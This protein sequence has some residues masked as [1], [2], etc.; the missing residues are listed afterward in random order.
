M[1]YIHVASA[2]ADR[3]VRVDLATLVGFGL[4]GLAVY[5]GVRDLSLVRRLFGMPYVR[6]IDVLFVAPEVLTGLLVPA[7]GLVVLGIALGYATLFDRRSRSVAFVVVLTVV[8]L[9]WS[10]GVTF[11]TTA[12]ALAGAF[13]V[14]EL[15][16]IRVRASGS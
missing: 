6:S 7:V 8:L 16:S 1:I 3:N 9:Y 4:A 10:A 14:L 13:A 12:V 11:A 15:I 5:S 2:S